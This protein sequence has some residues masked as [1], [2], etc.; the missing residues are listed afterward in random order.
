[1]S[2]HCFNLLCP[3]AKTDGGAAGGG[4]WRQAESAAWK[5]RA[6]VQGAECPGSG[7]VVID[8]IMPLM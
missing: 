7:T 8:L 5:E 2:P 3:A 1:M 6:G 4:I